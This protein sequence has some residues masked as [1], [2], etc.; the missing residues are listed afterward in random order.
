M[1][2]Q[3]SKRQ[4]ELLRQYYYGNKFLMICL[5]SDCCVRKDVRRKIENTL[6][7]LTSRLKTNF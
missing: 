3:F 2:N 1:F 5:N 6:L 7:L 4:Q